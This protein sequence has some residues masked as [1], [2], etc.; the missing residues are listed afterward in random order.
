MKI[1]Q[2]IPYFQNYMTENNRSFVG[3]LFFAL[4][5]AGPSASA[6]AQTRTF[7]E[8]FE[9]KTDRAIQPPWF[10]EGAGAGIDIGLGFAS[11]GRNN[12]YIRMPTG[13][14]ALTRSFKVM[15]HAKYVVS[16]NIRTSAN[17]DTFTWGCGM[18]RSEYLM[19]SR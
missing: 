16:A 14:N 19:T 17:V 5:L 3:W 9:G 7:L 12:A 10:T 6:L 13:W 2:S 8:H 1:I 11:H 18:R 4:C 15:T